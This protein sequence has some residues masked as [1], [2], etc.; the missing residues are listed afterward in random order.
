MDFDCSE[1][2]P[3]ESINLIEDFLYLGD[4]EA[5]E[6]FSLLQSLNVK[7]VLSLLED[8]SDVATFEELNYKRLLIQ[9]NARSDLLGILPDCIRF[10]SAAQKRRENV[11]VHC[12]AGISRSP[13]VVIAYF[14]VKYSDSYR[15][16]RICVN[17]GRPGIWPNDGFVAQLESLNSSEFKKYLEKD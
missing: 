4:L 11:L 1:D 6:N 12:A 14:M 7:H 2:F 3:A 16:A 9:D 5:A 13:S 15:A 17:R 8:F 10:I